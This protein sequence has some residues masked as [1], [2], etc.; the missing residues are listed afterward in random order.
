MKPQRRIGQRTTRFRPRL[1]QLECRITPSV[2]ADFNGDG[3]GDLA[4]GVPRANS[5]LFGEGAVHVVYG[6]AAGLSAD[7]VLDA[8]LW[9]EDDIGLS[10][11][12]HADQF[13]AAL[14]A[15]DF[16]GDG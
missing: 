7:A 13:G 1:E 8:Q 10:V 12:D 3:F 11:A 9:T 6:S 15:G 2:N 16:D 5:E 14:A 4:I